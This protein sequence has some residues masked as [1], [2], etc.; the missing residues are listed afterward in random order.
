MATKEPRAMRAKRQYTDEFRAGAVRLVLEEGKK[1]ADVARD[2]DLTPSALGLWVRRARA[3]R[4]GGKTGITTDE[5][6]ELAAMRKEL[7]VVKMERDILKKAVAFF[8]KDNA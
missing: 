1:V 6:A 4:T 8:A 5:R 2:L 7:R 3:D